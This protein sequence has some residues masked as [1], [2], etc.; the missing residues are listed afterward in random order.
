MSNPIKPSLKTEIIP[1]VAIIISIVSSFYFYS[2]FPES[3]PTHWNFAGEVDGWSS[4]GVA[5][6]L[7]PAIIAG[8]YLM[9]LVLPNLDPQKDRYEQFQKVYHVFKSILVCFMLA[10]YLITGLNGI[11]YDLPVG[12]FVPAMVGM[13]FV[14]IGNYLSKIKPNWFMGIRTPWTL[15]SEEVWNKTHRFG[16]KVFILSGIIMMFMGVLPEKFALVLF[17]SVIIFLTI[18]TFAY[19]FVI[20]KK[21]EKKKNEQNQQSAKSAD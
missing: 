10:I 16:G 14:V 7:F 1:L 9:F 15:S 11:G 20:Y 3:V 12:S 4:R 18:G 6:F 13:L 21:E 8:M 17:I 5:A 2:R 19:S